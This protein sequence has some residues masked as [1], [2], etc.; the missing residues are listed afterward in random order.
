VK[1]IDRRGQGV[2]DREAIVPYGTTALHADEVV[3]PAL[4]RARRS[5]NVIRWEAAPEWMQRKWGADCWH[6][7]WRELAAAYGEQQRGEI[8]YRLTAD[9]VAYAERM[10]LWGLWEV[11]VGE[12]KR[13]P[14]NRAA[15][16]AWERERES[17]AAQK[18]EP[19]TMNLDEVARKRIASYPKR[20]DQMEI[21][22]LAPQPV[23][24]PTDWPAFDFD[25]SPVWT[26][27]IE[28]LVRTRYRSEPKVSEDA[29][30]V[31]Q[32]ET[33]PAKS[34]GETAPAP[35]PAPEEEELPF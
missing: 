14:E 1:A 17:A 32:A 27:W 23:D 10:A 20:P 15:L 7:I 34:A 35:A 21:P 11:Q 25:R 8:N 6:A 5:G 4:E 29:E 3:A 28:T 2:R 22:V 24:R 33:D 31:E 26:V 13:V 12:W 16:T 9:D 30:G 19:K 18:R